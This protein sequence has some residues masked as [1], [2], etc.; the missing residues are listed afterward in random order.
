MAAD[1]A[2]LHRD[3]GGAGRGAERRGR[4]AAD[5]VRRRG[6]AGKI[7]ARIL[8][9]VAFAAFGVSYFLR[10]GY[11]TDASFCD[12]ML[13]LLVQGIAM[14]TFFLS[15]LTISLD[16]IPPERLPS[17]TGLSNF[18]RITAGSFAASLITTVWDRRE[19]LHQSRL[20]EAIGSGA[21][22]QMAAEALARHGADRRA[23]G[24]GDHAADGRAG[25]SAGVDR[26]VPAVG[27]AVRWR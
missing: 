27:V 25:V 21:P 1:P 9:T 26:P 18:A 19:A 5:A 8:A 16:G 20:S 17:A 6:C 11:T 22:Y 15:M 10:S 12:L 24:G 14:S 4:G 2:R 13:P 23:G 7:D 3:L